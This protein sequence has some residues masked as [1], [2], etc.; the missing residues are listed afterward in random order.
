MPIIR[1]YRPVFIMD[2]WYVRAY[3]V[4]SNAPMVNSGM[5]TSWTMHERNK[6]LAYAN[7]INRA[8]RYP[9]AS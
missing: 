1:Q 8:N 5:D 2:C 6:A 3:D 9:L 4:A 7:G